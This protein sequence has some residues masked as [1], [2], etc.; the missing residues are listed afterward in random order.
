NGVSNL[1]PFRLQD[2]TLLT[3]GIKNERQPRAAVGIIFKRHHFAWDAIFIALKVDGAI[4][5]LV[6]AA[7]MAH[8]HQAKVVPSRLFA[9]AAGQAFFGALL[10]QRRKVFNRNESPRLGIG[11]KRFHLT[12]SPTRISWPAFSDTMAFFHSGR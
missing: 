3:V 2:V 12:S 5:T 11:F 9:Q 4:G 7:L 1:E 6:A 8:N 10:R